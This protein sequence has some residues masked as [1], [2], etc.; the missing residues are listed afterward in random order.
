VNEELVNVADTR[1]AVV[2][3]VVGTV[4]IEKFAVY[5]TVVYTLRSLKYACASSQSS[6][7]SPKAGALNPPRMNCK[8]PGMSPEIV[9]VTAKVPSR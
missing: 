5:L 6:P 8:P 1:L 2:L 4:S 9:D 3:I 7:A